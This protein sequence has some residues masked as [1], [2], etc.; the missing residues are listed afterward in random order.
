MKRLGKRIWKNRAI[1]ILLLPGLLWMFV[2]AY[3]PMGGLSLAFKTFNAR[4]GIWKSPWAGWKNFHYLFRDPSFARAVWRTLGINIGKLLV[5]FPV[6]VILA[7]MF[8]EMRMRRYSKILQTIFTFPNFLSWIITSGIIINVLSMKGFVN[9]ILG[10]WGVGP[11]SFLGSEGW[12]VPML[13][14]S[15]IWKTSGWSAIIYIAAIAGIDYEQYEAAQIDGAS[16]FQMI[17]RVTLPNIMPTMVV[18]FIL[19]AGNLMTAGFDQ[20]FNLANAATKDVSEVLDVYIYRITFQSATDFSFS[21]AVSLFRSIIN[22]SL[23]LVADWGAKRFGGS[24][25]FGE[26]RKAK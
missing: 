22:M 6:P 2:F 25:L 19:A 26:G 18:M 20:I 3:M 1:Y 15:E 21:T 23:L 17:A 12:F 11:V 10:N 4:L 16:R 5:T 13:Y 14:L 9:G 8:N 7:L 24:G